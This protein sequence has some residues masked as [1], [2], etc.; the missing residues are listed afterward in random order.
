MFV[1]G[2]FLLMTGVLYGL[3]KKPLAPQS[4]ITLLAATAEA[5]EQVNVKDSMKHMMTSQGFYEA[6]ELVMLIS[7]R[8]SDL[9]KEDRLASLEVLFT[10]HKCKKVEKTDRGRRILAYPMK[11]AVEAYV[12]IYHFKGPR[13]M[14]KFITEWHTGPG[15]NSDGNV[16]RCSLMKQQL[17]KKAESVKPLPPIEDEPPMWSV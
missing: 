3:L 9:E 8:L 14:P 10:Q 1:S 6:Y 2:G 17:L 7:P 16:L 15:L 12:I 11:G 13:S 4:S 5:P